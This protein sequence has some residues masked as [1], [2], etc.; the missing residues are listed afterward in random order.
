L[1]PFFQHRHKSLL[2]NNIQTPYWPN[3]FEDIDHFPPTHE[4][5]IKYTEPPPAFVYN[6][7]IRFLSQ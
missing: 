6:A 5:C 3:E 2:I 4:I 1:L 7:R